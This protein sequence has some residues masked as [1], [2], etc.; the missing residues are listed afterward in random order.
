M[1][2]L[3]TKHFHKAPW[4]KTE[5]QRYAYERAQCLVINRPASLMCNLSFLPDDVI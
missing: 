5:E 1:A 2:I 4:S 3:L